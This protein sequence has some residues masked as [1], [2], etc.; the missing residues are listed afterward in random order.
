MGTRKIG[1]EVEHI[2]ANEEGLLVASDR[3][4]YDKKNPY[5]TKYGTIHE[6]GAMLEFAIDPT[7]TAE[8]QYDFYEKLLGISRE[9]LFKNKERLGLCSSAKFS[10]YDLALTSGGN[11]I[12]CSPSLS[13][14]QYNWKSPERYT[15]N[16]RYA[17][18]HVNIDFE[19]T[20]YRKK[21]LVRSLDYHLGLYSVINWEQ[22]DKQGNIKRRQSYGAGGN[23]RLTPFGV[24]Y[25]TLPANV[26]SKENVKKIYSLVDESLESPLDTF[27]YEDYQKIIDNCDADEA[28]K[29]FNA[30]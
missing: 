25:R 26:W 19:G 22:D 8:I 7:E 14:Y 28:R 29:V 15:D 3:F 13:A 10:E 24:E 4:G 11:S 1:I 2:L 30:A 6:D 5:K 21:L 20:D 12:G 18:L 27:M 9:K 17:G 23:Y 16:Y